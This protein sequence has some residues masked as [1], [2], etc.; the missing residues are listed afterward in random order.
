MSQNKV[1][2]KQNTQRRALL[3]QKLGMTQIWNEN[4]YFVPVSVVEVGTNVVTQIN[5]K[6]EVGYESVQIAYG[7][8]DPKRVSAG[9]RG[10]FKK[11]G[12]TPR[13]FVSEFRTEDTQAYQVGQE[14][15]V[16]TFEVGELL[17]V[18]GTTKGKGF[19]GV[20]KR[21]GFHGVR[22]THGSHLNHRK[23]G[24]VGACATPGRIFK[25]LRMSGRMGGIKKT[26]QKL[27][28]AG[29]DP[30]LG[31]LLIKGAIP[32]SKGGIVMVSSAA[33]VLSN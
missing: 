33:K 20:V 19:Q 2:S 11:A 5:R 30:E 26:I 21:H 24:S 22:A 16:D 27:P 13:R 32:G 25:G 23:P 15:A 1:K 8:I 3:G 6:D 18:S 9:L 12:V 10:H 17:D 4:G 29:V 14:L 28:L 7:N 31:Y